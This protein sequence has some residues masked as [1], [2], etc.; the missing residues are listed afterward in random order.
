MQ[1]AGHDFDALRR[2]MVARQIE[3]RG[4]RDPHVL[5]AMREVPREVFVPPDLA[6]MAYADGALPLSEGQTISQ[7]YVVALMA[8]AAEPGPGDRALDVGT[9]SG[10]AAAVLARIVD[11]VFSIERI[12]SLAESARRALAQAGIG[13]ATVRVGDGTL[14]WPEEAPFDCIVVAAGAPAAPGTLKRQLAHGGRLVIPVESGG[15]QTLTRIRRTGDDEYRSEE[16]GAV[17]FVPLI[18]AEGWQDRRR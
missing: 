17:Q 16:L 5:E 2:E 10:Y 11:H 15:Y 8:E 9:G 3:A 12:E 14:G 18:G 4:V 13:N 7:P 6:G 1:Q